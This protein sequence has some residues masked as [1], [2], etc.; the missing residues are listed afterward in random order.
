M[1]ELMS[2]LDA[3]RTRD[4]GSLSD[5]ALLEHVETLCQA[6]DRL[7]GALARGLAALDAR[8]VTTGECGRTTASWLIVE[9]RLSPVEARRRMSVARS[10]NELPAVGAATDAGDLSHDHARVISACLRS[11]PPPSRPEAEQVLVDAARWI[12]PSG[13]APVV[14]ALRIATG[15]DDDR[16]AAA[17]RR[18]DSR[19]ATVAHTYQ[20]ML[21]LQ[22][23]LDPESATTVLTA[24]NP[25]L[26]A[27][28]EDTRSTEQRRADALVEIARHTIACD[29]LP[30]N[31]GLRPQVVVTTRYDDLI[32][33]VVSRSGNTPGQSA[34]FMG[35][36]GNGVQRRYALVTELD[37]PRPRIGTD[38]ATGR[39]ISAADAR[40][41][42]C[43]A[44]ILP[45]VL[46]SDSTVLD[47]GRTTRTWSAGQRRAA[48]LRDQGCVFPRCDAG[49]D[50]C[51]LHHLRYWSHGGPSDHV[52]S[53]HLCHYHHWLIHHT[54]WTIARDRHGTV[55]V[56]RQ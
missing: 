38:V 40:R 7:D 20:G 33:S 27:T 35:V 6:R 32:A 10:L 56:S 36:A 37:V 13:L 55:A 23:M 19:W 8:Q 51:D 34:A 26:S 2:A 31:A 29:G 14:E 18:Y 21:H 9:Q 53:A 47:L 12:E 46:G 42:A 48:R 50:R 15:V 30:D 44:E 45:A 3:V 49:L 43:D 41:L 16:D 17:Q 22:A 11:L 25:L 24:I 28:S 52:N 39:P 1:S 4:L 5:C 54:P